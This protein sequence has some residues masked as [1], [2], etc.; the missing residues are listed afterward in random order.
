MKIDKLPPSPPFKIIYS[1]MFDNDTKK[2]QSCSINSCIES[3]DE[4]LRLIDD[5]IIIKTNRMVVYF[6]VIFSDFPFYSGE[7]NNI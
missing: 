6:G 4:V 5:D 3:L 2:V 1:T 7:C